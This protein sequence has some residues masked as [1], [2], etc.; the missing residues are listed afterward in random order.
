MTQREW[1]IAKL[2]AEGLSNKETAERLVITQRTAE[3]HVA[4][5]LTKLDCT[6]RSQV[7]VWVTGHR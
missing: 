4:D 5:I 3:T 1:Q 7:A 2:L 6:S